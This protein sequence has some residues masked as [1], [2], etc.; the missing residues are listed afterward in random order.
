M[1]PTRMPG[2][3][4]TFGTFSARRSR[5]AISSGWPQ[6]RLRESRITCQSGPLIGSATAPARQPRADEPIARAASGDAFDAEGPYDNHGR[7]LVTSEALARVT[8]SA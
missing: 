1:S 4:E 2:Q 7:V 8:R 3:F 6:L 5:K